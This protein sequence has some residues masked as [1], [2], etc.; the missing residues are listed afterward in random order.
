[1]YAW[2]E[3]EEEQ[4]KRVEAEHRAKAEEE[5]RAKQ[6]TTFTTKNGLQVRLGGF[7]EFDF[8]SDSTRSFQE[9]VGNR[10][11][12]HSNTVGGANSQFFMS[13]R[14]SRII[15]DVRAPEREGIKS[16]LFF[17]MDFL[18]NQPAVGTS[19]VT[20]F[21][22]MT[23]P[24]ARIFQLF[25]VAETPVVDVKVGQDWSVLSVLCL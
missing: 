8:I 4:R 7:A 11:V 25:F 15:L 5:Q 14:N 10:P 22:Q 19:G 21:S 13:P 2:V 23:S 18:G 1:M 9:L 6:A 17:A 24:D 3:A 20:E 16:R 12:A